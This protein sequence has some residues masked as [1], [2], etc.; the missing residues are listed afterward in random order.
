MHYQLS[1]HRFEFKYRLPKDLRKA[2]E[3]E[4]LYFMELD[5][6]VLDHEDHK[7]FV[8]SLY[9]D[10][11]FYTNYYEKI[12]G[13]MMRH[14][15]RIRTY[16][17]DPGEGCVIFL[18]VKGR[19]NQLVYKY[20]VELPQGVKDILAGG[21]DRLLDYLAGYIADNK[22]FER[23]RFSSH[24]MGLKARVLIDYYRRPYISKYDPDFRVTF[25]EQL[26]STGTGLLFPAAWD[27]HRKVLPGY[28]VLE[29]KFK[30]H[31]PSWFHRIIQAYELRRVSISKFCYGL[32]QCRMAKNLE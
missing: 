6:F 26:S 19:Y 22:V 25:D 27:R 9:F 14:K 11:D 32:E 20:R 17:D 2:V 8:R 15:F 30:R 23:F 31:V 1:F 29:V 5:P 18:E 28:S 10:D 13:M 7:Y 12:D 16:T 21:Q 24:R 4:L 3:G